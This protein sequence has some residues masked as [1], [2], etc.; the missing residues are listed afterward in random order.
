MRRLF[1]ASSGLRALP[2]L[3]AKDGARVGL[4]GVA[5]DV[6]PDAPWIRRDLTTF[7]QLAYDV[8]DIDLS[9]GSRAVD[10]IDVLFVAGGNTYYLLQKLRQTGF[11]RTIDDFVSAGG[12]YAGASAGAIVAGPQIEPVAELD[13]RQ[14]AAGLESTEGLNLVPFTVLPHAGTHDERFLAHS[15]RVLFDS[16][17]DHPIVRLTDSEAVVCRDGN[18][19]VVWSPQ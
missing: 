19:Q 12:I 2:D 17:L 1:L 5:A 16:A 11:D 7:A 18:C 6:Y 4:V 13:Q 15:S 14:A 9:A 10:G 8:V 3:V